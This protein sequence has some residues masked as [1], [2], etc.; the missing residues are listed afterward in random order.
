MPGPVLA[1][2]LAAAGCAGV[3][4]GAAGGL[5]LTPCHIERLAEEVLCGTLEVPEDRAAAHGPRIG[6]Q[7]A[8]LPPLRRAAEPDPLILLAGGPGQGARS[9][10]GI[11]ARYFRE[12]RR[13][14]AIVL[15]DLR[16][17]GGSNPLDC[18]RSD[19]ELAAIDAA[20]HEL[21]FGSAGACLAELDAD[22]R[23]YT[24]A[25]ALADLDEVRQRLGYAQVN[26]WG[27]SWGTRAALLYAL[28]Y[29]DAVR[30]VVLDGA[31]PLEMG[32]PASASLDAARALDG[33][34][35]R[36]A[37]DA[38]CASAYPDPRA[39]LD[40]L[41]ERLAGA[42]ARVTLRHPRTGDAVT[43]TFTRE[44]VSELLRVVLYT[45][46]DASRLF[47]LVHLARQGDFAPLA[48]QYAYSA[49][50]SIDE[51]ALGATL[52][53]L[54]SEDMPAS[55]DRDLVVDAGDSPFG[56]V[57]AAGW[58]ARCVGWPAG[59]PLAFPPSATAPGAALILS[60][61]HDPVTPPRWG[62]VMRRHFPASR[63]IVVPGAAHNASFTGCVPR[64]IA[65]FIGRGAGDG[66]D[67]ACVAD[68]P[69]PPI[70]TSLAGGR[71]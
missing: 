17:T 27:G 69:L 43:R 48:A 57:Y 36:C 16:G 70:V 59:P 2:L 50:M 26:L 25:A 41:L 53:V 6:I 33:L 39:E 10:A 29:P 55:A 60:G 22:P 20:R 24:H 54:C 40:G 9:F 34:V 65:E 67:A 64:L 31:V 21:L 1:I 4:P 8:V 63:H 38:D 13:D 61:E 46:V 52:A 56:I 28:T 45:P 5:E 12:V 49:S 42:P 11:A 47:H 51:M 58:R 7:V 23:H 19:D 35:D 32:F 37:R 66:L 44:A 30:S 62:E 14:R 15:V 71:P 68:V 18:L 3:P